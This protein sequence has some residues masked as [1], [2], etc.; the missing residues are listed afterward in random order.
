MKFET[1]AIACGF[2]QALLVGREVLLPI[3]GEVV[4]QSTNEG[5]A[6]MLA[7]RRTAATINA[8]AMAFH[9]ASKLVMIM[10]SK[11]MDWPGRWSRS[12]WTTTSLLV[13]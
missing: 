11:S 13:P 6:N 7:K 2:Q 1:Y 9:K 4:D 10:R 5:K 12:S 3:S 8:F